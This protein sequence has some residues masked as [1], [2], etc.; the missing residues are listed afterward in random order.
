MRKKLKE[1]QKIIKEE[2]ERI[3]NVD[4]DFE[5]RS[6]E[7]DIRIFKEA[8]AKMVKLYKGELNKVEYNFDMWEEAHTSLE[9]VIK[10]LKLVQ[11]DLDMY[12]EGYGFWTVKYKQRL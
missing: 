11:S 3:R 4:R 8:S 5:G 10:N 9:R 7:Y 6:V 12:D 1:V 2:E